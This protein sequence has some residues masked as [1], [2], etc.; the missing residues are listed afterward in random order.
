T[1]VGGVIL[2]L[3]AGQRRDLA[4]RHAERAVAEH[5]LRIRDVADQLA[6]AP[7]AGRVAVAGALGRERADRRANLGGL[8][9]GGRGRVLLGNA[10]H[11]AFEGRVVF[12]GRRPSDLHGRIMYSPERT[13]SRTGGTATCRRG[14]SGTRARTTRAPA[15]PRRSRA[16]PAR[17]S[18]QCRRWTPG[19]HARRMPA[20]CPCPGSRAPGTRRLAALRPRPAPGR[21]P[22][23]PPARPRL[24]PPA[25]CRG[26][27]AR[28]R[29]G[30]RGRG[31]RRARRAC[32]T[33][34]EP[35]ARFRSRAAGPA[36][37][38]IRA[39]TRTRRP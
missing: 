21:R 37:P 3:E 20:A 34:R 26:A 8:A 39:R 24:A 15:P 17:R 5:A 36:P 13:P 27:T 18:G 33:R 32:D 35:R 9:G 23:P 4:P 12:A 28:R 16:S 7:L 38:R 30:S 10:L 11:G 19:A 6:N 29:A 31:S 2:L 25:E 22:R 14:G 1:R